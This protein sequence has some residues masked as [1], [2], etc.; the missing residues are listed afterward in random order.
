MEPAALTLLPELD[1]YTQGYADRGR[2]LD[3]VHDPWVVDRKG[4]VTSTVLLDGR[5]V[6][7]WDPAE[8]PAAEVRL[9]LLAQLDASQRGALSAL[10]EQTA[11]FIH[12]TPAPAVEYRAMIPLTERAGWV[13]SPL[14]AHPTPGPC[15]QMPLEMAVTLRR[16]REEARCPLLGTSA[17]GLRAGSLHHATSPPVSHHLGGWR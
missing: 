17:L 13:R 9:H 6:G 2:Y 5:V 15:P 4:N 12:G 10:A 16:P 11:R 3:A 8:R 14:E 1:P 7:V